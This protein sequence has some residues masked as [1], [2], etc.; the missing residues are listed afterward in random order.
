MK[1]IW[2]IKEHFPLFKS[3]GYLDAYATIKLAI[4]NRLLMGLFGDPGTGKTTILENIEHDEM[5]CHYILCD[6][7][8]VMKDVL[9]EVANAA[10]MTIVG[11][12]NKHELQGALTD[13][14]RIHNNHVFLLDEC[15]NLIHRNIEKLD[16]LRQIHDQSRVPFIFGGTRA[17]QGAL[18]SGHRMQSYNSQLYRRL[19]QADLGTL[20]PSEIDDYL[21]LLESK[22]AVK[23]MPEVRSDLYDYCCD[24][25][26]GGLGTFTELIKC[27]FMYARPE[28]QDI[29]AQMYFEA[30]PEELNKYLI[31]G[32]EDENNRP[33]EPV[34]V[35]DLKIATIKRNDLNGALKIKVTK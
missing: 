6:T 8:M 24:C 10:G 26:N 23:F 35:G 27:M 2:D 29:S 7:N 31:D 28:W 17:L 13:Y 11:R 30:Y 19:Y 5:E 15:E 20:D 34:V 16:V 1:D 25:E 14:L 4:D 9:N 12:Q 32:Q 21:D 18:K 22:Y 33:F 3:R